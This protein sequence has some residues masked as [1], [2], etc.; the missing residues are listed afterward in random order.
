MPTVPCLLIPRFH[1]ELMS[2]TFQ[3]RGWLT[4]RPW[5]DQPPH[6]QTGLS[7]LPLT[8]KQAERCLRE[9]QTLDADSLQQEL[10]RVADERISRLG[11]LSPQEARALDAFI[12]HV[13]QNGNER[14]MLAQR[15]LLMAWVQ[16]E[17]IL[18]LRALNA[19][20]IESA[21]QLETLL[22]EPDEPQP[23]VVPL[24]EDPEETR[25]L[26]PWR[27]VLR[28]LRYF[29]PPNAILGVTDVAMMQFL[30][31]TGQ[32]AELSAEELSLLPESTQDQK[33][34]GVRRSLSVLLTGKDLLQ[35]DT[36]YP[37]S[38]LFVFPIQ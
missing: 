37:D 1:D 29:L 34:L 10:F 11:G 14:K 35:A 4:C 12:G 19:R 28:E 23:S 6:A 31:K 24:H 8:T 3:P 30:K 32:A 2:A 27:F 16:E 7:G 21:Q 13:P 25:L 9:W 38:H 18:A 5:D 26:P 15:L 33:F 22:A 36:D 20:Y 17:R